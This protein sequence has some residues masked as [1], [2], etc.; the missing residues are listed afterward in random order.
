MKCNNRLC[1]NNV[2]KSR[3]RYCSKKC[4]R[5]E[6]NYRTRENEKAQGYWLYYLPEEHYIGITCRPKLRMQA[7]KTNGFYVNDVEWIA[8]F[9]RQ[10][11][12]A[13]LE[14]MFHQRGYNGFGG[15]GINKRKSKAYN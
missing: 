11:D 15:L 7:H 13:W 8:N 4:S 9:E 10:V 3:R 5:R 14:I 2:P 6:H 1:D 12:A